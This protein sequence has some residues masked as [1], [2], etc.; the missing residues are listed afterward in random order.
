MSFRID[1]TTIDDAAKTAG[2]SDMI[3]PTEVSRKRENAAETPRFMAKGFSDPGGRASQKEPR[4]TVIN[5]SITG[6]PARPDRGHRQAQS[7]GGSGPDHH[8]AA[9]PGE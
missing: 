2:H 4:W 3:D 6:S 1:S 5:A 9:E 8:H 7:G